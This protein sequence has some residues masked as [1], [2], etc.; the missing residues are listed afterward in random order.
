MI[1]YLS[2]N[3]WQVWAVIAVLCLILEMTS[4]DCFIICFSFGA[5]VAAVAAAVGFGG[6]VQLVAFAVF[7]LVF[8]FWFRPLAKRYLHRGEDKRVSNADALLGRKGRVVETV[9]AGGYGRVQIDGD[10]WKA[11]TLG[12]GDIPQGEMVTVTDRASTII[13]VECVSE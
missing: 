12:E 5:L 8:L 10:V 1:D 7:T 13:T 3:L 2:Q 11:V 4:G 6:Y 9:R